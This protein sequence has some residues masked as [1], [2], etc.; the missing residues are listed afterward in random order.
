MKKDRLSNRAA[1]LIVACKEEELAEIKVEIIASK[2]GV[3]PSYLSRKFNDDK[4][5]TLNEFITGVKMRR[6]AMLL[7]KNKPIT[8]VA[9]AKRTG[10]AR[11]DYFV[12]LFKSQFGIHPKAYGELNKH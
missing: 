12:T 7:S 3:N 6:S 2:L 11:A 5:M 4:D 10:F 8:P 9:L 1:E